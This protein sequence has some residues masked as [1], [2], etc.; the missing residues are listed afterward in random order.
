MNKSVNVEKGITLI[1]LIITVILMLIIAGVTIST[2]T[3]G[4]WIFERTNEV[5][6]EYNK[7]VLDEKNTLDEYLN[8]IEPI[9][10]LTEQNIKFT[11]TPDTWTNGSVQVAIDTTEIGYTLQYS[12][13]DGSTWNDY[14]EPLVI[15]KNGTAILARLEKDGRGGATVTG[16]VENID[17]LPPK[18]F[19]PTITNI[20]ETGFEVTC[21]AQDEEVTD[22]SGKSGIKEYVFYIKKSTEDNYTSVNVTEGSKIYSDLASGTLYNIYVEAYDNAGNKTKSD[23]LEVRTEYTKIQSKV[24]VG[25]YIAY[26]VTYS[27]VS[28]YTGYFSSY[29]GWRVIYNDG[30]TVKLVSAGTPL[31]YYHDLN[32]SSTITALTTNFKTT[33]YSANGIT[34]GMSSFENEFTQSVTAMTKVDLDIVYGGTTADRTPVSSNNILNNGTYYWLASTGSGNIGVWCV[35]G[36]GVVNYSSQYTFGVRPVVTLKS[37]IAITGGDGTS[38]SPYVM[39]LY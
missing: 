16:N 39:S 18:A 24:A 25:D 15:T 14:V 20:T 36:N 1:A 6:A 27:N 5:A 33:S 2:V 31:S 4:I 23:T 19:K 13:N 37:N 8:I 35:Y 9:P 12:T 10:G 28:T 29:N 22:T 11:Y 32:P 30:T 3:G 34:G 21:E 17:V 26:P 7:A 38:D